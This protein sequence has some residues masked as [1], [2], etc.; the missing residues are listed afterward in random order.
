LIGQAYALRHGQRTAFEEFYTGLY[1]FAQGQPSNA[2]P[3]LEA[4]FTDQ[5]YSWSVTKLLAVVALDENKPAE[6]SELM[7]PY[8]Q[9]KVTEIDQAYIVAALKLA[10]GK[11][12]EAQAILNEF[13]ASTLSP[14][15][16]PKFEKLQAAINR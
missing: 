10:D 1:F 14:I 11:K 15:W 6:A 8:M 5:T 16:K 4:A 9:A 3:L 2:V 7:Q 12:A 13:A